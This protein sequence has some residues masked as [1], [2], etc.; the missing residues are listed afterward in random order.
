V[1]LRWVVLAL[2]WSF[3]A[4]RAAAT[5]SPRVSPDVGQVSLPAGFPIYGAHPWH[6][7]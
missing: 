7:A 4:A 1:V 5:V 3:P 2:L 6:P